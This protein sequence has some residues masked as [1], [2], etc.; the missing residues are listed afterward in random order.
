VNTTRDATRLLSLWQSTVSD[1]PF[2][3]I[4]PLDRLTSPDLVQKQRGVQNTFNPGE[5][6]LPLDFLDFDPKF[7]EALNKAFGG[8]VIAANDRVA[9]DLIA[10]HG[11]WNVTLDG[12]VSR[13]GSV[14]GGWRGAGGS[15]FMKNKYNGD[16]LLRQLES[17][18][19]EANALDQVGGFF[20]NTKSRTKQCPAGSRL[21][22]MSHS[23]S[24]NCPVEKVLTVLILCS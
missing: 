17:L 9:R 3:R 5:V 6:M 16:A 18:Q 20:I 1:S 8:Y 11:L 21:C 22:N 12:K 7:A 15:S 24:E 13:T 14:Q 23:R 19:K 10:N 4:W 2:R